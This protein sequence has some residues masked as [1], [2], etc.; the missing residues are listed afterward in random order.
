MNI[1]TSLH[2]FSYLASESGI[3][4]KLIWLMAVLVAVGASMY[5]TILNITEYIGATT[6][7]SINTTTASLLHI[8]F[9]R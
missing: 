4:K 5:F 6:S 8:Y 7:T 9:P 2:G 3:V 1:Q